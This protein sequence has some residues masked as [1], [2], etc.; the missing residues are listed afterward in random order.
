[1]RFARAQ[2]GQNFDPTP[3]LFPAGDCQIPT[4]GGGQPRDEK[5]G[6]TPTSECTLESESRFATFHLAQ[7]SIRLRIV[8][9]ARKI[10][11]L[12][13]GGGMDAIQLN[14]IWQGF[15][16]P[17]PVSD[18]FMTDG[19]E[20]TCLM[21]P[22]GSGKTTTCFYKGLL[23]STCI[24]PS[25]LDGV[26]YAKGVVVC[27]N[28]PNLEKTT[29]A[30]YKLQFPDDWGSW[31]GGGGGPATSV[32]DFR[33]E[34]GTTLH[35]EIIFAAIGDTNVKTFCDGFEVSW[36]FLNKL[37][38][39]PPDVISYMY[40]R[41]GRWPPPKHRPGVIEDWERQRRAWRKLFADMNAPDLDNW[42]YGDTK[43]EIPGF[44]ENVPDGYKLFVQPGGLSPGA[45]NIK[46][47]GKDYYPGLVKANAT[48]KWWVN[49]FV[50]NKWGFSQ[51][52]EAVYP[53]F[54]DDRHVAKVPLVF[55]PDR[56]LLLGFDAGGTPAMIAGQKNSY[57]QLLILG[58]FIPG[59][60]G[61]K[62]FGKAASAWLAEKFPGAIV[63]AWADPASADPTQDSDE[64][65]CW[66]ATVA[67]IME[68]DIAP[69]PSN[70]WTPRFT[71]VDDLLTEFVEKRPMILLSDE[72]GI[73]RK[74]FNSGYIFA[75]TK[76]HGYKVLTVDPVKNDFSHPHDALQYLCLGSSDYRSLLL[77]KG[78][79]QT[80][81]KVV[82]S[83]S[84]SDWD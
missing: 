31:K 21:G 34:D 78:S 33:L 6:V 18:A 54:D 55:N 64:D 79:R 65:G 72:C 58:E 66:L 40:S 52:G 60:M 82:T 29:I 35:Q 25:P 37:D 71:A 75:S 61:A 8:F 13:W 38:A 69:A 26:R 62:K 84:P 49:R 73:L 14:E 47:V 39:L 74:G 77:R 76:V 45:E 41:L 67:E 36:A 11:R 81:T 24:P 32:I 48:K 22:L 23:L 70:L 1:M 10:Q 15:E 19:N 44:V 12:G 51:D 46:N 5:P 2:T 30:S 28:Y 56:E 4:P 27:D 50:H 20:V 42:T 43:K 80:D 3:P 68:I 53:N 16:S 7:H 9:R 17:G 83:S 59:K 57:G 63:K